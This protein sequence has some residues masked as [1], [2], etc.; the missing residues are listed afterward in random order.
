MVVLPM[1]VLL[2]LDSV[3]TIASVVMAVD[4]VPAPPAAKMVVVPMAVMM[5]LLPDVMVKNSVEVVMAEAGWAVAEPPAPTAVPFV[6]RADVA[7]LTEELFAA[8]LLLA[9]EE[10]LAAAARGQLAG[11]FMMMGSCRD[12]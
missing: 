9:V 11:E 1:V 7:A 8:R 3:E 6:S 2:P 5:V 4:F 12:Y 10:A